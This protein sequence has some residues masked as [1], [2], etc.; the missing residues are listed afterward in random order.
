MNEATRC[1]LLL[2]GAGWLQSFLFVMN[3]LPAERQPPGYPTGPTWQ[4]LLNLIW[5]ALFGWGIALAFRLNLWLGVIAVPVYFVV[6]PFAFQLPLV[7]LFGF[8]NFREFS[9]SVGS[10]ESGQDT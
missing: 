9:D 8:Y 1:A 3:K 4:L 6:L 7:K 2:L 5:I 10:I